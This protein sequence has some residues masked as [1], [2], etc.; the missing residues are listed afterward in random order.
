MAAALMET[1]VDEEQ[2]FESLFGDDGPQRLVDLLKEQAQGSP[3]P[4]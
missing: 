2:L 4:A 3:A 1:P